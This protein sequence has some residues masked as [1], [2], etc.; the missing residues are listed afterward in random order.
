MNK[1]WLSLIPTL[2]IG[3][4][5]L[6]AACVN[7]SKKDNKQ[8]TE[9]DKN[10]DTKQNGENKENTKN[11][12]VLF[13]TPQ[14]KSWPLSLGV[15]PLVNYYNETQQNKPGFLP[16]KLEF[17]EDHK[18]FQEFPLIKNVKEK[19]ETNAKI[20]K[21][22]NL[23]LGAQSGAY[24]LSQDDRLLDVSDAGITTSI[25]DPK[26]AKIHSQLAGKDDADQLYNLP[27]DEA[28]IDAVRFNLDL[29]DLILNLIKNGGGTINE[30][31][32]IVKRARKATTVGNS[33]PE[34]SIFKLLSVKSDTQFSGY[35]VDD[36]TF[37]SLEK[38]REFANKVYD[39]VNLATDSINQN[40]I[41]GHILA[42]DYQEDA[43]LKELQGIIGDNSIFELE[44]T[45]DSN[46][47]TRIK[48]NITRNEA[49]KNK[50]KELWNVYKDAASKKTEV[51][52]G[53]DSINKKAFQAVKYMAN[54]Y[55]EWGTHDI[56]KWKTVIS[57]AASVGNNQSHKTKFSKGFFVGFQKDSLDA[58]EKY[59]E[60]EDQYILPQVNIVGPNKSNVYWE[61][62]SSLLPIKSSDPALNEGTK[63]FLNWLY[64]G[65]NDTLNKGTFE[66]NWLTLAKT[67]G[68]IIPLKDVI[69]DQTK[70]S[71]LAE[72]DKQR[73]IQN[74][75]SLSEEERTKAHE[76]ADYL[77]SAWISLTSILKLQ[78]PELNIKAVQLPTD[79]TT[80]NIINLLGKELIGQT[81][82]SS[83]DSA[84]T[85]EEMVKAIESIIN[86]Q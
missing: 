69:N 44:K 33:V 28:D 21:I 67:T 49:V 83:S 51:A 27:F 1:K 30:E 86:N 39:G 72:H 58:F 23:I 68:Y 3:V 46:E 65:T 14:G 17:F 70:Q 80:A 22:P 66:P 11:K 74:N 50:F 59:A 4:S 63:A 37:A 8:N 10:T 26:I 57:F 71:L 41:S 75:E 35:T 2:G 19:I 55:S 38:I 52:Y 40:T 32:D 79:D 20:E 62:G 34:N 61:G 16:V 84:K 7:N 25:F 24:V 64:L 82:I 78:D 29:L 53:S 5:F 54:G 43:F 85:D 77:S 6:A 56:A 9:N 73:A 81:N 18:F 42:I 48:Y 45:G 47:P 13:Q 60:F 36:S 76:Y 12:Q 31:A 15:I